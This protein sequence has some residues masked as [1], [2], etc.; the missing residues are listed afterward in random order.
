LAGIY[1]SA[2]GFLQIFGILAD[3]GLYAV[4]VREVSRAADRSRVLGAIVLLRVIITVLSL[5]S[6]VAIAWL[7]PSW[8]G[9][10]LPL[11]ISL[12]SLVPGFTLLAGTL[13]VVFQVHYQ[14]RSVFVAEVAQRVLTTGL[15]VGTV[16]LG[17]RSSENAWLCLW[18]L[19]AG[20]LGACLLFILSVW[21]SRPLLVPD[22]RWDGPLVRR[23][24]RQSLPYGLA[25]LCTALYRQADV[26]FI[27]L[28]RPDFQVQNAFYG[29]VQRIMDMGYLLPTF[30]L[31]SV[32]PQLS[33]ALAQRRSVSRLLE[34][35]LVAILLLGLVSGLT[36]ALWARPMM[37]LLTTEAYLSLPGRPGS[38]TALSWLSLSLLFNGL[39]TYA[40]YVLLAADRWRPL[41]VSLLCGSALSVALNLVLI[42]SAGFVGAA[43]TSAL[44]HA[45]LACLLVP[46]AL[47]VSPVRLAYGVVARLLLVS[48]FLGGWLWLVRPWLTS[49]VITAI[50]VVCTG[51]VVAACVWWLF[52]SWFRRASSMETRGTVS[53]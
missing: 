38:D 49:D 18:F 41:V 11:A 1:N 51:G 30:L 22:L 48:V 29:F 44:T 13:R 6:A 52:G 45:C 7:V 17:E 33:E 4:A 19:V 2:Y 40:F 36:C 8:Q 10:P 15:I 21:L 12:A 47:R 39:I 43:Q 50:A 16:L 5:G 28:L 46:Q 25:F 32:L 24:L 3:F 42:P 23:L 14:L 20:G 31:N 9:T 53:A 37:A 26:S 35:T 34:R 27:A